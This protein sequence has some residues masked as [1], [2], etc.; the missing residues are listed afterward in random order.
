VVQASSLHY[1]FD[2]VEQVQ[3]GMPAPQFGMLQVRKTQLVYAVTMLMFAVGMWAILRVG[4]G[5]H[6]ARNVAGDWQLN[7][8]AGV[9]KLPDRLTIHQSGRFLSGSL[10][11]IQ[12]RGE[13]EERSKIALAASHLQLTLTATLNDSG[14]QFVGKSDGAFSSPFTATRL[15]AR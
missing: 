3:A 10:G 11:D 14:D 8:T 1:R 2:S 9:S 12:V 13:L 15:P 7:G 6:A 5:L 4:S